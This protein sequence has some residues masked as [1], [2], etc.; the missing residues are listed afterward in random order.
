MNASKSSGHRARFGALTSLFSHQEKMKQL[1]LKKG[2][3][4]NII[5]HD[6]HGKQKR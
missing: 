1:P 4:H 5:R 2:M 3:A 6:H